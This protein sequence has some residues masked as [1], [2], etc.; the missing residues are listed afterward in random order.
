M[1]STG[2]SYKINVKVNSLSYVTIMSLESQA[3]S[4]QSV[5]MATESL[6]NV[7]NID[8]REAKYQ[9]WKTRSPHSRLSHLVKQF[10]YS[11]IFRKSDENAFVKCMKFIIENGVV[12]RY[13]S[14][15]N[16]N[17]WIEVWLNDMG[18]YWC[19]LVNERFH[20]EKL[21]VRY[22]YINL[23]S[24]LLSGVL[25][26]WV[27]FDKEIKLNPKRMANYKNKLQIF[28][29]DTLDIA[30]TLNFKTTDTLYTKQVV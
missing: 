15:F 1:C 18:K 25:K 5:T 4:H 29:L 20:T 26:E 19:N 11:L 27:T 22:E 2:V 12:V 16:R 3:I 6:G 9:K 14:S 10:G 13:Y 30:Q 7:K 24:L 21:Q 28:N 17:D 8:V 23:Y